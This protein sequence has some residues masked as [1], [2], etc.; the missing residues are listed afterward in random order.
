MG[1]VDS[2]IK[3]S[4]QFRMSDRYNNRA[5]LKEK[6]AERKLSLL[7]GSERSTAK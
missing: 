4:G 3:S 2:T 5:K 6:A 7:L 1:G